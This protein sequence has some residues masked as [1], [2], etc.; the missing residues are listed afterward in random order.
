MAYLEPM[1]YDCISYSENRNFIFEVAY[2][3]KSARVKTLSQPD[4]A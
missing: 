4:H 3:S 1:N 2:I